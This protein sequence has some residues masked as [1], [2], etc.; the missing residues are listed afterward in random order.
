M[1]PINTIT[2]TATTVQCGGIVLLA[3]L[4]FFLTR[5]IRREALDYWTGGWILLALA[6]S[7][8]LIAFNFGALRNVV[9][10]GYFFG[11]W[12]FGY[13]L[14][15][16]CRNVASGARLSGRHLL[17]AIPALIL[18]AIAPRLSADFEI[19]FIFQALVMAGFF[20]A[21]FFALRPARK[22][23]PRPGLR[24]TSVTLILLALR[25]ALYAPLF[26]Y[27]AWSGRQPAGDDLHFSSMYNL[28]LEI[29]LGFGMVMIVMESVQERVEQINRELT[30]AHDRLQRLAQL[31]PL[32][33]A[34][35]RHAFYSR[36]ENRR[37][38]APGKA[39]GTTVLLDIDNL[40]PINDT[41]GHSAGDAV[42]RAVSS[43]IRSTIRPEDLLFRWGGDEFLVLLFGVPETEAHRRFK[44]LNTILART[45]IPGAPIEMTVSFGLAT[46]GENQSIES[47]I[48]R[49]DDLMYRKKSAR[50]KR[51]ALAEGGRTRGQGAR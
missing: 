11:E 49:A 3:I 48:E 16:G 17:A 6:L 36:F 9:L 10:T 26:A 30:G 34:L 35:N 25:F 46:F 8:L 41:F 44:E 1:E 37:P 38:E 33:E 4:S 45:T 24:V 5:S 7:S 13:L 39:A 40:K 22:R 51:R 43:A 21:G 23:T 20:A 47:A 27:A 19:L 42:I 14:V 32:T 29:L 2:A 12:G 31:D 15:A 50:K 18:A 28:I